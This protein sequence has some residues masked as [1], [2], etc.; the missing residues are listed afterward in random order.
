MIN[1]KHKFIFIHIP[2]TGGTSIQKQLATHIIEP[3]KHWN[4]W[5]WEKQAG[6]KKFNNYFKFTFVRN[7][8]DIV[9]SKYLDRW[10]YRENNPHLKNGPIGGLA[11]KSLLY[12]LQNYTTIPHEHG[13][14]QL[15]YFDPEKVDFIG[16]FENRKRDLNTIS[17]KIGFNISSDYML[18]KKTHKKHYTEYYDD[19]SREIVAER[20]A[21]DIERFGYK[22]GE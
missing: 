17:Q 12:F 19:E 2:R 11:G 7:P 8:W 3:T 22:F 1:D 13:D 21:R 16:R 6:D 14:T 9:I 10:Y 20:Y 5:D 18:R 4:M 15:E